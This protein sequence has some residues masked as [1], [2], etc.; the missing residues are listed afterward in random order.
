M[1]KRAGGAVLVGTV[2]AAVTYWSTH[3]VTTQSTPAKSASRPNHAVDGAT[4]SSAA[5]VADS[6]HRAPEAGRT[7][8]NSSFET[9]T[10]FYATDRDVVGTVRSNPVYATSSI[11]A[12]AGLGFVVLAAW[13]AFIGWR[14]SAVITGICGAAAALL[15]VLVG[16]VLLWDDHG[17][18]A[19]RATVARYGSGRGEMEVGTCDVSIPRTHRVGHM[20]RP[21]LLRLELRERADRHVMLQRVQPQEQ[22]E[23][24]EAVRRRVKA[25]PRHDVFVF[26]HGYNVTFEA[27]AR[28]A[29]QIAYDLPFEGAPVFYSWPSQGKTWKYTVDENNVAWSVPHLKKFLVDLAQNSEAES[30]NLIAHSMGNRALTQAI[31]ELSLELKEQALLFDQVILAAP[32]IDADVFQDQLAPSIVKHASHV[33]LYASASDEALAASKMVHGNRRAGD[34]APR[35]LVV[36]G[37]DTIDVSLLDMGPL[38]HSYYGSSRF[39]LQDMATILHEARRAVQR[40]WLEAV[41]KELRDRYWLF[42]DSANVATTKA[43]P[44][45]PQT[46]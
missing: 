29:A 15:I 9:V 45:T 20:E 2:T 24:F 25:S 16:K 44:G 7:G 42:S 18:G 19:A 21:S 31:H 43:Q 23:F 32:D 28:R 41:G 30:I 3:T 34:S 1:E 4:E 12:A 35:P 39:I 11:G 33:T 22:R 46:R 8:R 10:V 14:R 26:V 17:S 36:A 38:G 37:V 40:P 5:P 6:P 13:L 27:A